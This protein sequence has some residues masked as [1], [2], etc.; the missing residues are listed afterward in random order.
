[1][2]C[3]TD[4]NRGTRSCPGSLNT[5]KARVPVKLLISCSHFSV[6]LNGMAR[7]TL[8]PDICYGPKKKKHVSNVSDAYCSMSV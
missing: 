3:Y 8:W 7:L 5:W 1:M 2:G 4:R 6:S